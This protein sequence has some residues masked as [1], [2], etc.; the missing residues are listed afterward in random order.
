V[1]SIAVA[2]QCTIEQSLTVAFV[3]GTAFGIRTRISGPLVN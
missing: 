3:R 2:A 1:S